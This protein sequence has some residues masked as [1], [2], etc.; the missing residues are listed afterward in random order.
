MA[1]W[2]VN[3][4]Q[5]F[6]EEFRGGYMWAPKR[7]RDGRKI[8]A[9]EFMKEVR[10]NDLVFS[11]SKAHIRAIGVVTRAAYSFEKP[12]ELDVD[13]NAD[14]WRIE[15][16]YTKTETPF[17]PKADWQVLREMMPKRYSPLDRNGDGAQGAY[18][19]WISDDLGAYIGDRIRDGIFELPPEVSSDA[20]AEYALEAEIW[21][22]V[23]LEETQRL[24][25]VSARLGQGT[26][27][28]RVYSF[29]KVCRVTGVS[30]PRLL[31]ASHIKPW[32]LAN[33]NE[34]LDGN[35][36]LMLSPHVDKLLDR[37][38]MTFTSKGKVLVDPN[39][40]E[41]ILLAWNI[42]TE[43]NVGTFNKEQQR[44]LG[45]H[46]DMVFQNRAW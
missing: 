20:E 21:Q 43:K 12:A 17:R 24:A 16:D 37:G 22:D 15:V 7:T 36:G 27:K 40:D 11:Y 46:Q 23:T 45:Y 38:L 19:S 10:V 4:G 42:D 5:T 14:G 6:E 31:I 33:P 26:F 9:Y 18:L 34:R 30:E 2:W 28:K 8:Q 29:E 3:Q 1:T 39:L 13:W 35:N 44:F 25:M 32:R 41:S